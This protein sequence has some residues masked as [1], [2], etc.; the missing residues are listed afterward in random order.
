M[1][2][3]VNITAA[4]MVGLLGSLHCVGMCGPI[5]F[6][7]PLDRSSW[8]SKM[9]GNVLYN[10][11][12]LITYALLGVFFGL[13]G[14]SFSLAG[15]QQ[16]IS[17]AAGVLL[18]VSVLFPVNLS[19]KWGFLYRFVSLVKQRLSQL[20]KRSS[21]LNLF[22]IG[23]LN[24]LLP[25]GLVYVAIFGAIASGTV[26]DA[27]FYMMAFGLGTI[28]LMFVT[29]MVGDMISIS[30]KNKFRR[31]VPIMIIIIGL[32]FILRGLDLGIP[33]ISP[34]TEALEAVQ[35]PAKCH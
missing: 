33:Y 13:I 8:S 32:L 11:G 17:I 14:L 9:S 34:P 7:L 25:C 35:T 21:L 28:P 19:A 20:F 24:G 3:W 30:V 6:A 2:D 27:V 1:G 31:F 22:S 15:W 16:G 4:F 29:A 18:I 26:V 10:L 12:R 23:L 5:A